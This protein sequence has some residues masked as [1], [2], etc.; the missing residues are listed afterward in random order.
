MNEYQVRALEIIKDPNQ[1][2]EAKWMATEM[3][4]NAG[5]SKQQIKWLTEDASQDTPFIFWA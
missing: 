3:L 5:F 2:H 1:T 4:M